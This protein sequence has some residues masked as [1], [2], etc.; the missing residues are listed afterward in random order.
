MARGLTSAM[1]SEI[2]NDKLAPILLL[3][4]ELDSGTLFMWSGIGDIVWNGDTYVGVGNLLGVGETVE[5]EEV[6]ARGLNLTL[7]GIPNTMIS[8]ALS[9]DYQG[10]SVS[11][12]FGCMDSSLNII[13][14]PE[15]IFKGRLDVMTI[16]ENA[17]TSS[18]KVSCENNLIILTQTKER[19]YTPE[20]QKLDY[21][22][23][24]FFDQV[25]DLQ[26]KEITWGR[27]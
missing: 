8:L 21:P 20:D 1:V 9:E 2:T 25:A 10:R 14:D 19:T 15:M 17:D 12:W 22:S 11:I 27:S 4:I 26:D 13:A 6:E 23:D 7:S 16:S 3:K 5:T 18:I 24:T